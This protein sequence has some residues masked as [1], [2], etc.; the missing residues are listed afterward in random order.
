M[1]TI[2]T[3]LL[4]A[5]VTQF[6]NIMANELFNKAKTSTQ[7]VLSTSTKQDPKKA[8]P[9]QPIETLAIVGMRRTK[10]GYTAIDNYMTH[11][12]RGRYFDQPIT[13]SNNNS[14]LR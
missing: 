8:E 2:F 12:T 7:V 10:H 3:V 6:A 11:S 4:T 13:G 9:Q 14:R 5:L 1:G